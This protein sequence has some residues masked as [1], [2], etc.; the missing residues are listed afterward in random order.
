[1]SKKSKKCYGHNIASEILQ[2]VHDDLGKPSK[3]LLDE[4]FIITQSELEIIGSLQ[5]MLDDLQYKLKNHPNWVQ[6]YDLYMATLRKFVDELYVKLRG[7]GIPIV[8]TKD[9]AK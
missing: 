1:M 7:K 3:H 6:F 2:M 4:L 5:F 8:L 9:T